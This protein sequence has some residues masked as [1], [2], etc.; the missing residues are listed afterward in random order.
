MKSLRIIAFYLLA[1]FICGC[2]PSLHPLFT[3]EQ[4]ITDSNLIGYWAPNDSNEM[5]EI[6][7]ADKGYEAVYIDE[8]GK[9]GKFK[10]EAG[11]IGKNLF[12]D[13]Y[14]TESSLSENNFYK[15]HLIPAHTFV[16]A[17]L[18]NDSMELQFINP[19]TL[20][21]MLK[22]DPKIVRNE[23]LENGGIVLTASTKELQDFLLK[24]G[25][26]ENQLFGKAKKA[27]KLK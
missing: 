12:L 23:R 21:K 17:D 1:I 25:V 22:A 6:K 8:S 20:D 26:S 14:P 19:E 7:A 27:V 5:W 2:V 18:K 11:K 15:L 9:A 13:I 24:Y 4:T 10:I 3:Q 16:K